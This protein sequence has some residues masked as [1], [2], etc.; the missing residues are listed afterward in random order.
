MPGAGDRSWHVLRAHGPAAPHGVVAGE[1]LERAAR[2]ERRQRAVPAVLLAGDHDERRAQV[3]RVGDGGDRVAEAGRGVEVDEGGLAGGERI[4]G[5]DADHRAL[6][7]REHVAQVLRQAGQERDL[8]RAGVAEDRRHAV[9]AHDVEGGVPNRVGHA[10]QPGIDQVSAC[11]GAERGADT[12][13]GASTT[14]ATSAPISAK[15]A[16]TRNAR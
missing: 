6:V 11:A 2:E 1:R 8:R 16:P 14:P 5:G 15:P 12:R 13:R 10:P 7:Q 3:A 9:A 4:P